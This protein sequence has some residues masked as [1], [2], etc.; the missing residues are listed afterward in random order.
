M[1][2][3][4]AEELLSTTVLP[5]SVLCSTFWRMQSRAASSPEL[6]WKAARGGRRHRCWNS[7]TTVRSSRFSSTIFWRVV[8]FWA[9]TNRQRAPAFDTCSAPVFPAT[10][11]RRRERHPAPLLSS[12]TRS[13]F[14]F[15]TH[16]GDFPDRACA[17][18]V[19][20]LDLNSL[21]AA[22]LGR[23]QRATPPTPALGCAS[24]HFFPTQ[25]TELIMAHALFSLRSPS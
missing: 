19:A 12:P 7:R 4:S 11:N 10:R 1:L 2:S 23:Q 20:Q 9:A 18:S 15:S 8:V 17:N 14:P 21:Q 25:P 6:P 22:E 5:G 13:L 24:L 16:A 3:A